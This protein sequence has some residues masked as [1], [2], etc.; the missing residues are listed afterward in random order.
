MSSKILSKVV[1]P[2]DEYELS[3]YIKTFETII[4]EFVALIYECF[5]N[6]EFIVHTE[7]Y[8][9]FIFSKNM[10]KLKN[11]KEMPIM[12][13]LGGSAY[14]IYGKLLNQIYEDKFNLS[15]IL[16]DSIDYDFSFMM[17]DTFTNVEFKNYIKIILKNSDIF[18]S[19][20][21]SQEHLQT[22]TTE[23]ILRDDFLKIRSIAN[24]G[25]KNKLI[26]TYSN[27]KEYNSI[28]MTIK[29]KNILYQIIE[30]HFWKNEIISN[31]I[32]K[33][34]FVKNKCILYI[35]DTFT[36]LLPDLQMLIKSNISSLH[37]RIILNDFDKCNKDYNRLA[38]IEL[39]ANCADEKLI[40]SVDNSHS[41]IIKG[42]L[43]HVQ[44]IYK[45]E[46]PNIFKFP[47]TICSLVDTYENKKAMYKI[48]SNFL[49]LNLDDQI[50]IMSRKL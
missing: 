25:N 44:R 20:I 12:L 39:I 18:I 32:V 21:N 23:D 9:P 31:A 46:N 27:G 1:L 2:G 29:Y 11:A 49:E 13:L 3:L 4:L 48:Y 33:Q 28:Q 22:I 16:I 37:D 36:I 17:K 26:I 40:E 50:K 19:D 47:N 30:L 14:K 7:N 15:R 8:D 35:T 5:V 45:K 6:D 41:I 24:K 43:K 10:D 34:S 42:I 38:F